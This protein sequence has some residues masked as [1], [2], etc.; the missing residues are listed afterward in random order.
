MPAPNHDVDWYGWIEFSYSLGGPAYVIHD[1]RYRAARAEEVR[2]ARQ[3]L[4]SRIE[5]L[6]GQIAARVEQAKSELALVDRQL[7]FIETTLRSLGASDLANVAHARDSLALERFV[8]ESERAFLSTLLETLSP[9]GSESHA[10][11]T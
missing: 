2:T 5:V 7:G 4:T 3:E 10:P 11:G 1:R 9:L 8:A 6:R